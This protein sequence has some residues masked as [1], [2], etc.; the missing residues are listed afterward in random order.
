MTAPTK[1]RILDGLLMVLAL[2]IYQVWHIARYAETRETLPAK[3]ATFVVFMPIIVV[4]SVVW[5]FLWCAVIWGVWQMH[6]R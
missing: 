4:L 3:I 5:G 2:P 6:S 1:R